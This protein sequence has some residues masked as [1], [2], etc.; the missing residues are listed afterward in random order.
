MQK[1]NIEIIQKTVNFAFEF[2]FWAPSETKDKK[3]LCLSCLGNAYLRYQ[4]VDNEV[5]SAASSCHQVA[6]WDPAMFCD[7]YLVKNYKIA[8]NSTTTIA[9]E[10]MNTDFK[11]LE[12]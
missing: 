2:C 1:G 12:F 11:S 9:R 8:K 7:F 4:K 10:K 5:K 6:A 3:I